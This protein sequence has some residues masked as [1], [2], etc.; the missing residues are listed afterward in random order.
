VLIDEQILRL[1]VAV[2]DTVCV[3]EGNTLDQLL[4]IRLRA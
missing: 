3:A 2:Q 1:D 4:Q